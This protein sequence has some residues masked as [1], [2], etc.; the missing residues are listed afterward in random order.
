MML[1]DKDIAALSTICRKINIWKN[2]K[3]APYGLSAAQ[4]PIVI[5]V[6]QNDGMSQNDVVEQLDL[7]KSVV[8]KSIGKLI[9]SGYL[10]RQKN[11]KDKRAFDLLPTPK[12]IEIY[13]ALV[14]QGQQCMNL[15]TTGLST[16]EKEQLSELLDKLL[17]NSFTQFK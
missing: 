6:C 15:L 8:A 1:P 12:A 3:A 10:T 5:L 9:T 7:E 14:Q 17:E 11:P 2:E 16:D 4:V 13:P